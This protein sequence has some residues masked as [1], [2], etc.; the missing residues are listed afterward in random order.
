[1]DLQ[2]TDAEFI[3]RFRYF[4]FEEVPNEKAQSLDAPTR[5]LVILASLIGCGAVEAYKEMLSRALQ[6][7]N[8]LPVAVKEI[9]YQATDYVG[10]G[11]MFPFLLATNTVLRA[12]GIVLPVEKQGTTT[13]HDR[14]EKGVAIQTRIFGEHMQEAW[15]TGHIQR[16]LAENCFGDYYTRNGLTLQERELITFCFLMA[17]GSCG[18]QLIAHVKG[19][20]QVGNDKDFLLKTVSQCLPYIGYPRSLNAVTCIES[21][22]K[23]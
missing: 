8:I 20:I 1:M 21:A 19:N 3:E 10:Y 17:D 12:H 7:R 4:A 9:V 6:S 11:R 14:L 15:K 2:Y 23:G 16:W 22:A 18:P 5:Y 13:L